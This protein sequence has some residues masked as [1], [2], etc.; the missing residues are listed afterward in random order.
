MPGCHT[1]VTR[2]RPTKAQR[3]SQLQEQLLCCPLTRGWI[4]SAKIIS[5][6]CSSLTLAKH[7]VR[8]RLSLASRCRVACVICTFI[9]KYDP[10]QPNQNLHL[11]LSPT[12]RPASRPVLQMPH[13]VV[14]SVVA[15]RIPQILR[16]TWI[17]TG[18][19]FPK[20]PLQSPWHSH[21][22]DNR[23]FSHLTP[24]VT[25]HKHAPSS[26][27]PPQNSGR[28]A[29]ASRRLAYFGLGVG[30]AWYLDKEF[31]ASAVSRNVRT[32]WTVRVLPFPPQFPA[33]ARLNAVCNNCP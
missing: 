14:A 29:T 7:P 16:T 15:S 8:I 18:I 12:N 11:P 19:R 28:L 33:H 5:P 9:S 6:F 26:T 32:L 21:I 10:D 23:S 24:R 25:S 30:A 3:V 1:L 27:P 31:N 2:P 20:Q 4:H 22:P 13:V 17:R